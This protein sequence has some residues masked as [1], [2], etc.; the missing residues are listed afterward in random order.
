MSAAQITARFT[1]EELDR[2]RLRCD[3]LADAVLEALAERGE[4]SRD[5]LGACRRLAP[6]DARCATFLA[7]ARGPLP[8]ARGDR[9]PAYRLFERNGP[10]LLLLGFPVLVDSY[11]GAR[12]NKVLV[13]SGRLAGSGAFA[14]LVETARFVAAVCAPG[15]LAP[16]QAG[17]R[18]IL[19]V[20]LLHAQVRALCRRAGFDVAR[21]DEPI[22]QEAMCGTLML[23]GHGLLTCLRR[24]G[25]AVS[26]EEAESWHGLWREVGA[27][28]GVDAELLPATYAEEIA[29]YERI[30]AHQ[31]IP[32]GDTRALFTAAVA[33]VTRGASERMPLWF[34][35]LGGWTLGSKSFLEQLTL[36]CVDPLLSRHLGLVAAPHWSAAFSASAMSAQAFGRL[37]RESAAVDR[38]SRALMGLLARELPPVLAGTRAAPRYDDPGFSTLRA[39]RRSSV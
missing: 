28:L 17:W 21:Y 32:D 30:K 27:R 4:K 36:R 6:L 29:R 37:S 26:E 16:E 11:A 33:D 24:L 22:N 1:F 20:R 3:P 8:F 35:A 14:R 39:Q 5:L 18:N 9:E 19:S 10:L 12:D 23:F 25:V 34:K 31:F 13:L 2:W 38:A 7:A 15:A